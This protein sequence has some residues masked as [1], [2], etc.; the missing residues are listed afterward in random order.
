MTDRKIVIESK[1]C[2]ITMNCGTT[3]QLVSTILLRHN[4]I[5]HATLLLVYGIIIEDSSDIAFTGQKNCSWKTRTFR[6]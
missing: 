3:Q 1:N 6:Q 2:V 5:I 4:F